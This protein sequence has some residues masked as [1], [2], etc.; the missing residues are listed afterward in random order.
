MSNGLTGGR[1][2]AIVTVLTLILLF[3]Y[4]LFNNSIGKGALEVL[5]LSNS[6]RL[7]NGD[8]VTIRVINVEELSDLNIV[9]EPL[10][11][12][13][14]VNVISFNNN[15][16][17]KALVE[18]SGNLSGFF[19]GK[20]ALTRRGSTIY[21][22]P[23]YFILTR[24]EPVIETEGMIIR[25]YE[26]DTVLVWHWEIGIPY[27]TNS[28]LFIAPALTNFTLLS[29]YLEYE[30]YVGKVMYRDG[31]WWPLR[32]FGAW[33]INRTL[34]DIINIRAEN[35][36]VLVNVTTIPDEANGV[37]IAYNGGVKST[38]CIQSS[39]IIKLYMGF[40]NKPYFYIIIPDKYDLTSLKVHGEELNLSNCIYA[41]RGFKC[42]VA[43]SEEAVLSSYELRLEFKG[44]VRS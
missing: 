28:K 27:K 44:A 14:V 11:I 20:V 31:A 38:Q 9:I 8:Y 33:V 30:V 23:F 32:G 6:T 42:Y 2:L 15:V 35:D 39:C 24:D 12:F 41:P 29:S 4:V 17:V 19:E 37:T 7:K 26:N 25:V 40:N 36:V 10:E 5:V 13:K 18:N 1:A 16:E 22:K 34:S 21:S 43:R 3:I